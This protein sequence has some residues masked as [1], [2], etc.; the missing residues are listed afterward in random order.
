VLKLRQKNPKGKM[1]LQLSLFGLGI[2]S[3]AA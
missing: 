1:S 2:G 3:L